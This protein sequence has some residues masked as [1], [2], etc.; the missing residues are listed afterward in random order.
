MRLLINGVDTF[1]ATGGREHDS[2][3]PA[4]I[5]LHGAGLD[6]TVWALLTR[7]FAHRGFAA[8][9]PDLPGHGHSGGEALTSVAAMTDWT[10]AL[11]ETA[12]ARPAAIIG[13]SMGSLIA[14]ELA[15]RHPAKVGALG[16]I[17][18]AAA[19]PVSRDL[20][21]A[22]AAQDHAAIDMV[23]IWG[24][25]FR[26]GV[27][28]SLAPGLW[29]LGGGV[30]LVERARPG[31]LFRDLAA[32]NDYRDGLASA[33]KATMP[34]TLV[35]GERDLMTP[36]KAGRAL[37]AALP[38]ARVVTLAGAGHMLMSERPDEVLNALRDLPR[39]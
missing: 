27:G 9:A 34:A 6:H 25:G 4:V 33:A 12:V 22:A 8:L 32:C 13:H 14:L 20:L 5:F 2:T 21:D 31:V 35:L 30:R 39:A 28:G 10:A 26:A 29:M 23:T 7:W 18:T 37:A 15:A 17:G 24:Y 3:L 1:V 36:A 16:L 38:N 19:M 11:I